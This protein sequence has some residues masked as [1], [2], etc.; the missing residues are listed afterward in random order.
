MGIAASQAR[1]LQCTA[2]KSNVEYQGQQINEARTILANKSAATYSE[3]LSLKVPTPPSQADYTRIKYSVTLGGLKIDLTDA[4]VSDIKSLITDSNKTQLVGSGA[5]C[6]YYKGKVTGSGTGATEQKIVI[7][8]QSYYFA[9]RTDSTDTTY[10]PNSI[11]A[12]TGR[13]ASLYLDKTTSF[14]NK[15]PATAND[16]E[17]NSGA[18][19]FTVSEEIDQAAYDDAYNQYKYDQYVYEKEIDNINA[20]TSL[21]HQQDQSLEL[22]LKQLDTE[23]ATLKTELDAL[24]KV[25]KDDIDKDYKTFGD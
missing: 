7:N 19:L 22:Q 1:F 23:Q 25:I 24:D 5:S 11:N 15:T 18:V 8:G 20:K 6:K 14:T 10:Y 9:V 12:T 2:R 17:Y 3:M 21:I 4:E 16:T 13:L